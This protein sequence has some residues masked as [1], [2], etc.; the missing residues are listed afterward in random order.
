[1]CEPLFYM[2]ESCCLCKDRAGSV[3]VEHPI[4][5][6]HDHCQ[7]APTYD[8]AAAGALFQH[9]NRRVYRGIFVVKAY[10]YH[11]C[12]QAD[13]DQKRQQHKV[14]MVCQLWHNPQ[15]EYARHDAEDGAEGQGQV[16][17]QGGAVLPEHACQENSRHRRGYE[18]EHRLEHVEQ[19]HVFD[20]VY[21]YGNDNAYQCAHH[22]YYVARTAYL[23]R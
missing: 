23:V 12:Y 2:N 3:A 11:Y 5:H 8:N 16:G 14:D 7:C 9:C 21:R 19:I 6:D 4:E 13:E 15:I 22:G 10:H 18:A 1:M 17:C 20:I